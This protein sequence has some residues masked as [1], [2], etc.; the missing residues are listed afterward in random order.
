MLKLIGITDNENEIEL[1][2]ILS[3][4][5]NREENVPADDLSAVLS[6]N[7][8]LPE[9][10]MIKLMDGE[11]IVFKG[12]VDEQQTLLTAKHAY[13]KLVARSMAAV[14][15]DNESEPVSYFQPSTSVIFSHHI[16][17]FGIESYK[18]DNRA[19][20]EAINISKGYSNWKAVDIFC[21]K[22][23]GNSP[24]VEGDGTINFNGIKNNSI[25]EFSNEGGTRYNSVKENNRRCSILSQVSVKLKPD[26]GYIYKVKNPSA[27]SKGIQRV[28]YLDAS[29][30]STAPDVA[31]IMINNGN[32]SS[33]EL[34]ITTNERLLDIIGAKA[35][36]RDSKI[37]DRDGLY[38][39][40]VY[41]KLTPTIETTTVVLKKEN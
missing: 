41:Y 38:V 26:S 19:C 31:Q 36:L 18:G 14:L 11:K 2:R 33:Y 4:T 35:R 6:Y 21:K 17:P 20:K 25:I 29:V 16:K 9:L 5:I 39:S 34:R 7:R 15:L 24:R 13:N 37:G 12:V 32:A 10:N 40:A 30:P 28:R 1:K 8:N 22:A 23:Y 3:L 27:L